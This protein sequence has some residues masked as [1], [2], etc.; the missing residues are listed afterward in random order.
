MSLGKVPESWSHK[1]RS[2]MCKVTM[3]ILWMAAFRHRHT[4]K[5]V[6][7]WYLPHTYYREGGRAG[8]EVAEHNWN[9]HST[10]ENELTSTAE[11]ENHTTPYRPQPLCMPA[12]G[13]ATDQHCFM[14]N[15]AYVK[16][17]LTTLYISTL[18]P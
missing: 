3:T 8:S 4:K 5:T 1:H 2:R 11:L 16:L 13:E 12:M 9:R 7:Q 6:E 14:L 17:L 15:S 18:L 10:R